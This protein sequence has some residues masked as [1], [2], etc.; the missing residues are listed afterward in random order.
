M[1]PVPSAHVGVW[2][3]IL[4]LACSK[5]DAPTIEAPPA[6][7][8]KTTPCSP[9]SPMLP[10][11]QLCAASMGLRRLHRTEGGPEAQLYVKAGGREVELVGSYETGFFEEDTN[12]Q[13]WRVPNVIGVRA[14]GVSSID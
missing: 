14:R 10:D 8:P 7:P 11:C 1:E 5:I 13:A 12:K 9:S 2:M 3:W 6:P 4:R